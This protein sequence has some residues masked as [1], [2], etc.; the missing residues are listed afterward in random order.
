MNSEL[1]VRTIVWFR[2]ND[3]RVSDH[4][5][6]LA[7]ADHGEVIPLFVLDSRRF[8]PERAQ[9]RAHSTQYLLEALQAL[10]NSLRSR[11]SRL[12]VLKG[13][14][15][16]VIV[17]V[18]DEW[19][20]DRVVAQRSANPQRRSV[21]ARIARL[22]GERFRLFGGETLATPAT[23]LTAAGTSYRVFSQ[24]ARTFEQAVEVPVPQRP[25][26]RLNRP[27]SSVFAETVAIPTCPEL[28]IERNRSL[29][30]GGE[31][32]AHLRLARTAESVVQNYADSRDR[33]DLA[34]TSRLSA[35]LRFGCVSP[36]QVWR[37]IRTELPESESASSFL[38]QLVWREFSHD[39]LWHR[40]DVMTQPFRREFLGFPWREDPEGLAAWQTG[41]TGYPVVDAAAR[42]LLAEGFVHNRARMIAASFL[43]KHLMLDHRLGEEHYLGHLV[44][45]D[46]IQNIVG[47]Q[48]VV[49]SGCG[50]QP[51][52]RM[53]NPTR[54]GIQFDPNGD[55]VRRWVPELSALPAPFIHQPWEAPESILSDS[56]IDLGRDYP[57]P[58]VDHRF[59]RARFLRVARKH[60][61]ERRSAEADLDASLQPPRKSPRAGG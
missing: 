35:D 60:L 1:N 57:H 31:D 26:T 37:A 19:R 7:G 39:I 30:R 59:A 61:T 24:Y 16:D 43:T 2:E 46:P 21:D 8:A 49:G 54:Q 52:F 12:V 50:A 40:P 28:G 15:D 4:E 51:Y 10:D 53:L 33:M 27:P 17:R 38:R 45:G 14:P 23:V 20:A 22:L 18:A 58:I 3:L 56:G 47:W 41:L 11:G 34:T 5:P 9:A 42:Q 25:P 36:R 29:I 48:W 13:K 55:Y 32:A 44:D 6:L